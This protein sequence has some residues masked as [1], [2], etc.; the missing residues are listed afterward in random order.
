[1]SLTKCATNGKIKTITLVDDPLET[2]NVLFLEDI[3]RLAD[4]YK[5]IE[6]VQ[7]PPYWSNIGVPTNSNSN[8]LN[9][10]L[11]GGKIV[12]QRYSVSDIRDH[13]YKLTRS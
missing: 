6:A 2:N 8:P 4:G 11:I 7:M 1:M 13:Y 9:Q 12:R 10:S 5:F 3:L